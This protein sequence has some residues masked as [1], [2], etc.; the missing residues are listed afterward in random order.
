VFRGRLKTCLENRPVPSISHCP[1]CQGQVSL[2]R[3]IGGASRVRCP[4][5]QAEYLLEDAFRTAPPEL[6]VLE[7]VGDVALED[8]AIDG[9]AIEG[10]RFNGGTAANRFSHPR[11][12]A[13]IDPF[14]D[15]DAYELE[16]AAEPETSGGSRD[17][18]GVAIL[19]REAAMAVP[20]STAP[21]RSSRRTEAGMGK[22]LFGVIGGGFMGLVVGYWILLWIGGPGSDFLH[23]GHK[24]PP[25]LVPEAFHSAREPFGMPLMREPQGWSL[26]PPRRALAPGGG[27]EFDEPRSAGARPDV[28]ESRRIEIPPPGQEWTVLLDQIERNEPTGDAPP[29]AVGDEP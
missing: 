26:E 5:C 24:L 8:A 2:P 23:I 25:L 11:D 19:T 12:A 1:R 13:T 17:F 6:T 10:A 18:P 3:G 4:L 22:Q 20:E 29:P 9:A 14:D 28:E 27:D 21:I 15:E 16:S 7:V